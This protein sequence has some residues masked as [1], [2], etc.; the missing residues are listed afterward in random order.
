MPMIWAD[1]R[2]VTALGGENERQ[3]TQQ[4]PRIDPV[5]GC[6]IADGIALGDGECQ[7]LSAELQ[8]DG[9]DLTSLARYGETGERF[10]HLEG[11]QGGG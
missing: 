11:S 6:F 9:D 5:L 7:G 10:Q 3:F 4:A 8:G 1:S 2:L